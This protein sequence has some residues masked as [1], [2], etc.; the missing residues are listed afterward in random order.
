MLCQVKLSPSKERETEDD[1]R[2]TFATHCSKI[3]STSLGPVLRLAHLW[4]RSDM[5]RVLS[6]VGC[7]LRTFYSWKL[8]FFLS[9]QVIVRWRYHLVGM[10]LLICLAPFNKS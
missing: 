1:Q 9:I 7:R 2:H 6:R 4:G 3:Y 10:Q 5:V 8:H